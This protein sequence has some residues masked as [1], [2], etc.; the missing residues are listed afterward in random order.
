MLPPM[1][2]R[3]SLEKRRNRGSDTVRFHA[4]AVQRVVET[5]RSVAMARLV[6]IVGVRSV[7]MA[8]KT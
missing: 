5:S 7:G 3:R 8:G 1:R 6:L 4:D 2:S